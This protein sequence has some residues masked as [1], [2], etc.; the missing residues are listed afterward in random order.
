[1]EKEL[2]SSYELAM[3]RLREKNADFTQRN[4]TE[5]QKAEIAAIK[6]EYKAKIAERA[7]MF[8][9]KKPQL[10]GSVPPEELAVKLQELETN[11]RRD[12]EVLRHAM[13][14]KIEVARNKNTD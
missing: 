11:H 5:T 10:L 14:E 13:N 9:S 6:Q 1:M 7:I 4:L 3:E 8:A 2:K 12:I